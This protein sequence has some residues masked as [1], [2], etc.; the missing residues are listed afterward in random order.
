MAST[1]KDGS[2]V[3]Y[4]NPMGDPQAPPRRSGKSLILFDYLSV[5]VQAKIKRNFP[6]ATRL[7]HGMTQRINKI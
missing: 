3:I 5:V 6:T 2:P 4:S 7:L 1:R